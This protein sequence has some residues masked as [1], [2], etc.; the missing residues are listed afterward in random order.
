MLRYVRKALAEAGYP[1]INADPDEV[2]RLVEETQP[3]L[4]LIHQGMF[5]DPGRAVPTVGSSGES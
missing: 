4:V 2:L 1:Q 3:D 5:G